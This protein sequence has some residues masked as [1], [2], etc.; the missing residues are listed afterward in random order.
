MSHLFNNPTKY[1]KLLENFKVDKTKRI[2]KEV[3]TRQLINASLIMRMCQFKVMVN[4]SETLL[5]IMRK[6]VRDTFYFKIV[7]ETLGKQFTAGENIQE[8]QQIVK[9][10]DDLKIHSAVNYMMEYIPGINQIYVYK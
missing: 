10:L 1:K 6:T 8:C 7:K 3:A 9:Y 5:S 4:H 2:Y